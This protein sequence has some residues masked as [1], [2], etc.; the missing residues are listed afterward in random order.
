MAGT[1]KGACRCKQ[2]SV[3]LE[4]TAVMRQSPTKVNCFHGST[5]HLFPRSCMA[6]KCGTTRAVKEDKMSAVALRSIL[7]CIPRLLLQTFCTGTLGYFHPVYSLML[8]NCVGSTDAKWRLADEG[9]AILIRGSRGVGGLRVGTDWCGNESITE[10]PAHP[11]YCQGDCTGKGQPCVGRHCSPTSL[12][13]VRSQPEVDT[14]DDDDDKKRRWR[15]VS[16]RGSTHYR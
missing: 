4:A 8:P 9:A 12:D 15:W 6:R 13:A 16:A 5:L 3:V 11:E 7:A 2:P 14:G 1:R 10:H